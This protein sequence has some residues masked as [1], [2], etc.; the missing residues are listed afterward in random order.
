[1]N[2]AQH[3]QT[4]RPASE[5]TESHFVSLLEALPFEW[6][7]VDDQFHIASFSKNAH[8]FGISNSVTITDRLV[9]SFLTSAVT[10]RKAVEFDLELPANLRNTPATTLRVRCCPSQ[11]GTCVVLLEDISRALRVDA[12]RKDFIVNVSH[13]LKTPVGALL[14]LAE[15]IRSAIDDPQSLDRFAHRIQMEAER[16]SK[17]VSDL[18][19]LSRLQT[20]EDDLAFTEIPARRLLGEAVDAVRIHAQQ[21][22]IEILIVDPEETSVRGDE[23]QLTTALC[24]LLTNAIN[25]SPEFTRVTMSARN[26]EQFTEIRV[27]DQGI[28][29]SE[30]DRERIFERFYRVDPA[31]SR[32]TGGTGLGLAIVKHICASHHGECSVWSQPNEGSTF[33]IRLPRNVA[34]I[35]RTNGSA[36]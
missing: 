33:T 17:L 32:A 20:N 22:N 11:N 4:L 9:R 36:T 29:I 5:A 3:A 18:T 25:Y 30:T 31:R 28:G 27:A 26:T 16:L 24:N 35:D 34:A 19:E 23:Q 14:L 10:L 21:R 12:M 2:Q 7:V 8:D 1:M 13:E 6:F 15:A